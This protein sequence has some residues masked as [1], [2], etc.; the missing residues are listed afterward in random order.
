MLNYIKKVFKKTPDY[1]F[2]IGTLIAAAQ[3]NYAIVHSSFVYVAILVM[4]VHELGHYFTSKKYTDKSRLP[5]FIPLPFFVV[6]LTKVSSLNSSQ[7]KHVAAA[8]PIYG[9]IAAALLNVFNFIFRFLPLIPMLLLLV[10]EIAFNY[11]GA[12]G[13]KYRKAKKD[14]QLCIS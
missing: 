14:I 12:D 8:G 9:L 5:I 6:G 3:I 13:A 11:F 1:V 4:L 10:G 2:T 7:T